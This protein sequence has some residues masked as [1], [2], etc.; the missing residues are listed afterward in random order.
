LGFSSFFWKL[1]KKNNPKD[2]VNPV[3][4][5]IK[6]ESIPKEN[7]SEKIIQNN[8]VNKRLVFDS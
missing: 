4:L 3:Q 5:V 6:T 7:D 1:E 8:P 2:P